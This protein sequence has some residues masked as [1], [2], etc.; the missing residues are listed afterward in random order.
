MKKVLTYTGM[1]IT[2]LF[3]GGMTLGSLL[4][5]QQFGIFI[6]FISIAVITPLWILSSSHSE[7][8]ESFRYERPLSVLI[9]DDDVN[10]TLILQKALMSISGNIEIDTV[11][12]GKTAVHELTNKNYDLVFMDHEMPDIKGPEVVRL[13]DSAI[14]MLAEHRKHKIPVITYT[15]NQWKDWDTDKLAY[16][17]VT[18][19][20]RKGQSFTKMQRELSDFIRSPLDKAAE[21]AA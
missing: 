16:V 18:G 2:V 14:A 13:A 21:F 20:M 8:D 7:E 9:V 11:E 5:L 17:N 19:H 6:L 3:V 4:A 12:A 10:S 15:A 1:V